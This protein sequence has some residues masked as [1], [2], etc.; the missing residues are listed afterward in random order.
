VEYN[1]VGQ[2]GG[3]RIEVFTEKKAAVAVRADG[4]ERIYLPVDQAENSSYYVDEPSRLVPT[5]KGYTVVHPGEVSEV[6]V[7]SK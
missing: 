2:E 3:T 5:E 1:I 7:F 4:E 6:K